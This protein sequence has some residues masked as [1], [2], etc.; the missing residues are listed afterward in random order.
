MTRKRAWPK[1]HEASSWRERT[2][3]ERA[4][5]IEQ[6]CRAALQLLAD[7]PDRVARLRRVDPVPPSTLALLRRLAAGRDA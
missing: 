2:I 4:R 1:L 5:A 6:A 3:E 7:S